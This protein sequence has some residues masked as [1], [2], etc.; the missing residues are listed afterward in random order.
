MKVN[1]DIKHRTPPFSVVVLD[2]TDRYYYADVVEEMEL[3]TKLDDYGK[4]VA[5]ADALFVTKNYRWDSLAE[6]ND[7]D[8]GYDV[9]VYNA[10]M[11]CIYAAHDK[12]KDKWIGK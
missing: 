1:K 6:M 2:M 5:L 4:A 3:H 8:G 12:Y 11:G 7:C 9:R 10:D